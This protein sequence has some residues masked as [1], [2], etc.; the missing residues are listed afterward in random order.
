MRHLR[1]PGV[2]GCHAGKD[3]VDGMIKT[4]MEIEN[5]KVLDCKLD[6][7]EWDLSAA[8]ARSILS[9]KKVWFL[10]ESVA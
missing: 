7:A 6:R 4:E 5:K 10:G 2:G 8:E 1:T 3:T 9:C